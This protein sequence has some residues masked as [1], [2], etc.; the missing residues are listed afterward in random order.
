M[1]KDTLTILKSPLNRFMHQ[2]SELIKGIKTGKW[3]VLNSI[4][5]A[6]TQIS[7]KLI[8]YV[9]KFQL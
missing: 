3:I 1:Q 5:M 2:D 6:T 4:E 7:E 8:H 9:V